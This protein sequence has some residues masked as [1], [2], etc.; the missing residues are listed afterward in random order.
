MGDLA[1]SGFSVGDESQTEWVQQRMVEKCGPL[2]QGFCC[3]QRRRSH[4]S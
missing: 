1:K 4:S 2:V 3:R